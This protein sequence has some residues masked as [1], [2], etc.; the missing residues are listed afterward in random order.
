M[1]TTTP[2]GTAL[3]V[4]VALFAAL[5]PGGSAAVAAGRPAPPPP[6]TEHSPVS[7]RATI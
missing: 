2:R 5:I 1:T 4:A 7:N 6:R 3:A